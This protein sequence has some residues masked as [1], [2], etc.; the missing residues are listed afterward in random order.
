VGQNV[1]KCDVTAASML[2]FDLPVLLPPE[3]IP[4]PQTI[5]WTPKRYLSPLQPPP[6]EEIKTNEAELTAARGFLDGKQL[7]KNRPRRTVDYNG[8][9]GRWI[10]VSV[11]CLVSRL[12][13][14]IVESSLH[15]YKKCVPIPSTCLA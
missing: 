8:S 9:L 2:K 12:R 1:T 3:S 13:D 11:V 10:L 14:G 4:R 7:K 6:V 15:S 5:G